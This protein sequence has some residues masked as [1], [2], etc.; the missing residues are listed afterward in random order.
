MKIGNKE[1]DTMNQTYIMGILNMTPDSFTDGGKYNELD[2]ALLHVEKMIKDGAHIIDV[3][4]ESTRPGYT[5]IPGEEE[6]ARVVPVIEAIKSRFDVPVSVDT[7]KSGV[8]KAAI[9]AGVDMINDIW[10]LKYDEEM[11]KVI[12]Q[13]NL[14]CCLVHNRQNAEYGKFMKDVFK[15]LADIIKLAED[16][17]IDEEKIIIDPGIGFG[18]NC[19]HNLEIISKLESLHM[20]GYPLLLGASGKSVVGQI[21]DLPEEERLEGNELD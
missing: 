15:E 6:T 1:F 18:K 7:C 12:A 9:A 16:A 14:P 19:E 21:L 5:G 13:S 20:F 10:G 4:G 2:S 3:G 8:A 11:A 17:G